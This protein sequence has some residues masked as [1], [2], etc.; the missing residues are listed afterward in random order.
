M[1]IAA[2]EP[3]S[4]KHQILTKSTLI[5]DSLADSALPPAATMCRPERGP[6]QHD[7]EDHHGGDR[8]VGLGPVLRPARARCPGANGVRRCPVRANEDNALESEVIPSVVMND[9]MELT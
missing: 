5:P 2:D 9:G 7:K 4:T 3:H 1:P 6:A 8:P